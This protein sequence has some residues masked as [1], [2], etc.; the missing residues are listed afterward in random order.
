MKR[1][2]LFIG[3]GYILGLLI[4]SKFDLLSLGVIVLIALSIVLYRRAVWKYVLISTLSCLIA[5]CSYWHHEDNTIRKQEQFAGQQMIFTGQITE[6]TVYQNRYAEYILNG[7]IEGVSVRIEL[8]TEEIEP[9]YGDI[10]VITGILNRITSDY[11]FDSANHCKAENVF[12]CFDNEAEIEEIRPMEQR[13]LRKI[14]YDWRKRMTEQIISGMGTDTG[15][16]LT[17]MLFGDKSGMRHCMK[18]ALYRSGIGHILAVSGL[19]LDFL[20]LCAGWILKKCKAGR[21]LIFAVTGILCILFMLCAGETVSVKRACIMILISQSAKLCFRQSNSFNSLGI[22]M[23]ILGIENPFVI[24]N[25][26]FWLSCSG[27]FGMGTVAAYMTKNIRYDILKNSISCILVFLT[28][29]P[30]SAIYFKEISLI[31]PLTNLLLVPFCM[32]ALLMGV[33][34]ICTGGTGMIAGY[35]LSLADFLIEL[36]LKIASWLAGFSWTHVSSDSDL[37]R[38]ALEI[39]GIS[40]LFC[41]ILIRKRKFTGIMIACVCMITGIAEN[42]ERIYHKDDLKIAVLGTGNHCLIAVQKDTDAVL[43]DMTGESHAADYAATYLTGVNHLEGLYLY[44]P[45]EKSIQR[46]AEYFAFLLPESLW[47]MQDTDQKLSSLPGCPMHIT[48]EKEFLFHGAKIH[49]SEKQLM[50]AYAGLEYICTN[51]KNVISGAPDLLTVY[52]KCEGVLPDCGFLV[53]LDQNTCYLP[54]LY[55]FVHENNLEITIAKNGTCRVRRLYVN[56]E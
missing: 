20:A 2:A 1:P 5:C 15:A 4:A 34:A 41:H 31:S 45:K 26:A 38:I 40:I 44:Q 14:I 53:I 11:L 48:D 43:F 50:I 21:K 17:G 16:C 24:H 32:L 7:K 54:D 12:L 3:F 27:A 35:C 19:H 42:L 33:L 55:T 30:V 49:V 37:F 51:E 18:T 10:L 29:L 47:L 13:T 8:F 46:Y 39:G 6:K 9:D 52:G 36:I 23:L 56:S 28:V 25:A 22:A